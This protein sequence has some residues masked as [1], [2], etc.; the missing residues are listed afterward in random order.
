MPY[1]EL[2]ATTAL[3][4]FALDLNT[5][6]KVVAPR[7]KTERPTGD[8]RSMGAM[9]VPTKAHLKS[10]FA[11]TMQAF[12]KKIMPKELVDRIAPAVKSEMDKGL[13]RILVD[14]GV[15]NLLAPNARPGIQKGVKSY[16][17]VHEALE[18]SG[19]IRPGSLHGA[20]ST[21]AKDFNLRNTMTGRGADEFRQAMSPLRDPEDAHLKKQLVDT[22]KDPRA[23]QFMEP[24]RRIPG[25][26][27]RQL[28]KRDLPMTVP[29]AKG[30]MGKQQRALMDAHLAQRPAK[31]ESSPMRKMTPA[32]EADMFPNGLPSAAELKKLMGSDAE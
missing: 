18:R 23:A 4:K 25:A 22:F 30:I 21:F 9:A 20:P 19:P 12:Q 13:G 6:N 7:I 29:A 1:Y 28:D 14:P 24:G 8:L 5:L 32:E 31:R 27:K 2:G 11:P 15:G 26:M 3:E 16:A 10:P 17:T